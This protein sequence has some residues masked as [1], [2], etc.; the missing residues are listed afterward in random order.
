[1]TDT[2]LI[3]R[4]DIMQQSCTQ[5]GFDS[6]DHARFCRQ[7]GATLFVET[8]VSGA[9]TRNYGRQTPPVA[10]AAPASDPLPPSVGD[11]LAGATERYY[12][13]PMWT[14]PPNAP[15]TAPI[16]IRTFPR[17][18]PALILGLLLSVATGAYFTGREVGRHNGS[19]PPDVISPE[20]IARQREDERWHE[21]EA[22]IQQ[23]EEQAR[24]ASEQQQRAIEHARQA[25]EAASEAGA[26]LAPTNEKLLDLTPYEYPGAT[27]GHSV[28]LTGSEMLSQRTTDEFD[29][30]NQFY[31]KKFGKPVI[32]INETWEKRLLFQ[33]AGPPAVTISVETD[34]EHGGQLKIVVLRSPFG[35]L[36][37]GEAPQG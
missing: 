37:P 29:K 15:N 12:Q 27:I 28:R 11:A 26:A 30:V 25:A 3:H 4:G 32:Q 21:I 24:E 6:P 36:L 9:A 35:K 5:C 23:A 18:L 14:P 20:E 17:W 8:D 10:A 34:Y 2:N 33:V 16:P 31:Q 13:P 19:E 7:C 22:L 1:L